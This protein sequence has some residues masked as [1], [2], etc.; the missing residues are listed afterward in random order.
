[1]SQ[2]W[3]H[4]DADK[5]TQIHGRA[6]SL[7]GKGNQGWPVPFSL[8]DVMPPSCKGD[9]KGIAEQ[10]GELP[11]SAEVMMIHLHKDI[12]LQSVV[13][14]RQV[15]SGYLLMEVRCCCVC[16]LIIPSV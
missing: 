2:G 6:P 12:Y 10:D 14:E 5:V 16:P 9:R 15:V 1:M 7:A 13:V 3:C 11:F 4:L 8:S